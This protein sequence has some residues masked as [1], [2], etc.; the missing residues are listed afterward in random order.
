MLRMKWSVLEALLSAQRLIISQLSG[1]SVPTAKCARANSLAFVPCILSISPA[2]RSHRLTDNGWSSQNEFKLRISSL[3][4]FIYFF[5]SRRPLLDP[6]AARSPPV[7]S[8][9]LAMAGSISNPAFPTPQLSYSNPLRPYQLSLSTN[10]RSPAES[11]LGRRH[12]PHTR[13]Q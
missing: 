2:Q 5:S 8:P 7:T 12:S 6:S 3:S 10:Q 4:I 9:R 13:P 1:L 11:S